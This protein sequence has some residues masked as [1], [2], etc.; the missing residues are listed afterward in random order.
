MR[1]NKAKGFISPYIDGELSERDKETFEYHI[2]NCVKCKAEFEETKRLN[3][4][5][6]CSE[7]FSAPY[8]L[9]TRILVNLETKTP[10]KGMLAPLF[11]KFAETIGLLM[12][13]AAGMFSGIV[14]S[15]ILPNFADRNPDSAVM[16]LLSL[17]EFSPEPPTS[18]GGVYFALTGGK[19]EE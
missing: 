8:G 13:I 12:V 7:R 2:N 11:T 6:A 4:L 14:V 5:F 17:E 16:V 3:D 10:G 19:D 18:L 15:G 1:C 9:S